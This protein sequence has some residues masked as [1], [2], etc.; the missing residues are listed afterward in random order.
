MKVTII[1]CGIILFSLKFVF[2]DCKGDKVR[3][4][5]EQ[6]ASVPGGFW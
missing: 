6:F 2:S 1:L 5:R 3:V 4:A